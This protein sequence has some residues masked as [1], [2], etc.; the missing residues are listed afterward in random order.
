M[1]PVQ[2]SWG[3]FA[4]GIVTNEGDASMCAAGRGWS[5]PGKQWC[6]VSPPAVALIVR[7]DNGFPTAACKT[8]AKLRENC[9]DLRLGVTWC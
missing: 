1:L 2:G 8:L 5:G 3:L 7:D 6:K 4:E 9:S